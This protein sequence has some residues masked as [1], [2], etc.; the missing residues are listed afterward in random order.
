MVKLEILINN[1]SQCITNIDEK[2]DLKLLYLILR[3]LSNKIEK[4]LKP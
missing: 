2:E 4:E 1:K 3:K